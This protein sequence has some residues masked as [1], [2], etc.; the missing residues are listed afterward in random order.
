MTEN[1][2]LFQLKN[3]SKDFP[4]K[5]GLLKRIIGNVK[6]VDNVSLK[7]EQGETLGLVGE[8]GCGKTTIARMMLHLEKAT[9][10][11]IIFNNENIIE[12]GRKK[13]KSYRKNVQMIFQDPYSSLN[14]QRNIKQILS[15]PLLINKIGNVNEK[16]ESILELVNLPIATLNKYPHELS[17]G[18][19]Q[20]VGIAKALTLNPKLIVCDEPVS[21]LDVS[22]RS[23]IINLL[24]ELQEKTKISYVFISHDLSLV[25]HM[26]DNIAIMYLGKIVEIIPSINF[27][28]KHLHPYTKALVSSIPQIKLGE[29][30]KRILLEGDVPSPI[31][32]PSG[33]KFRTRCPEAHDKCAQKEPALIEN[34]KKHFVACHL[35]H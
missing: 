9:S 31:N 5:S 19:R 8:S 14:P 4:I 15:E 16:I 22:I 7:I 11:K 20:R 27:N 13:V 24:L 18:Q 34:E 25:E 26:S 32:P 1:N 21:A 10:G 28:K 12:Y 35:I 33:C 3:V 23:Q 6:A 2:F 30:K 17:G 29:N